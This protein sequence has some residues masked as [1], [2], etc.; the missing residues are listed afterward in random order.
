MVFQVVACVVLAELVLQVGAF[1]LWLGQPVPAASHYSTGERRSVLCV[2]DSWTHG[3]GST[4]PAKYSYPA[5]VEGLL[6]EETGDAW[7]VVNAGRPGRDSRE[8]LQTLPSQL[9]RFDPNIVVVLV[10]TND[11]WT[12]PDPLQVGAEAEALPPASF[13]WRW[14]VGRVV[15]WIAGRLRTSRTDEPW[16]LPSVPPWDARPVPGWFPYPPPDEPW[17]NNPETKALTKQGWQ[18]VSEG[19]LAGA[20]ALFGRIVDLEPDDP[21]ARAAAVFCAARMGVPA[22]VE[23]QLDWLRERWREHSEYSV[24][25]SLAQ[26]LHNTSDLEESVA[27]LPG[28]V[29]RFPESAELHRYLAIACNDSGDHEAAVVA[30]EVA[31][32]MRPSARDFKL[33]SRFFTRLQRSEDACRGLVESYVA[34]NDHE[35]LIEAL[36][37]PFMNGLEQ[38]FRR[39]VEVAECKP[40]QRRRLRHIAD[41]AFGGTSDRI[42]RVLRAHLAQMIELCRQHQARPVLMTYPVT[43][44]EGHADVVRSAA[45]TYGVELVDLSLLFEPFLAGRPQRLRSAD[46]HLNDH[47]YGVMAKLVAEQLMAMIDRS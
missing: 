19:D 37:S 29:E 41:Y 7:H 8:A 22:T 5:V 39:V 32:A 14:R 25:L 36:R 34:L 31:L 20:A 44:R 4:V 35:A 38:E 15:E 27:V 47:G 43:L 26:A 42:G 45:E 46:G 40:G 28:M 21:E 16:S 11:Y 9:E 18:K 33:R 17:A 1:V 13:P 10:G 2:G 30:I 24:A 3:M 6:S 23:E 12:T